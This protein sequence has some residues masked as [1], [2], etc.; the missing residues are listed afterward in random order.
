MAFARTG[1][2]TAEHAVALP[3]C[4]GGSFI[5]MQIVKEPRGANRSARHA[6]PITHGG[7]ALLGHAG[8]NYFAG[9][10][11][12]VLRIAKKSF[13]RDIFPPRRATPCDAARNTFFASTDE[14]VALAATG[15]NS[16]PRDAGGTHAPNSPKRSGNRVA[17]LE[18]IAAPIRPRYC[19]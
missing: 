9:I 12:R 5:L 1:A 16:P 19:I 14:F 7:A 18:R 13:R 3:L 4:C 17:D 15:R 6:P 10:V 2:N 11:G 8:R